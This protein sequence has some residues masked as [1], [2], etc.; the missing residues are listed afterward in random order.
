MLLRQPSTTETDII[1][2]SSDTEGELSF[3]RPYSVTIDLVDSS[4]EGEAQINAQTTTHHKFDVRTKDSGFEFSNTLNRK[5]PSLL[6]ELDGLSQSLASGVGGATDETTAQ[7]SVKRKSLPPDEEE[8]VSPPKKKKV[9]RKP[10]M[11]Q[12]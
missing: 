11:N 3:S 7:T 10:K 4:D 6:I 12:V 8:Q 1:D 9:V 2:L 5:T